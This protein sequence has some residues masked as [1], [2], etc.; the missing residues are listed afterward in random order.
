M[1]ALKRLAVILLFYA[2]SSAIRAVRSVIIAFLPAIASLSA[3][4]VVFLSAMMALSFFLA[5]I[6]TAS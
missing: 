1:A 4:I 3:A 5:F 2:L 6:S